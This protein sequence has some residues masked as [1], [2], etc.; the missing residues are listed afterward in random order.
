MY[1]LP[2][3]G[4]YLATVAL[5]ARKGSCGAA[6]A[7][8]SVRTVGAVVSSEPVAACAASCISRFEVA[9]CVGI[10]GGELVH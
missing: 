7:G 9:D 6:Q 5:R 10:L 1:E 8:T 3:S 4:L 2:L